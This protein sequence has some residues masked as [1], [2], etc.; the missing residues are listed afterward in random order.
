M[1]RR[2]GAKKTAA[3]VVENDN[4]FKT[5]FDIAIEEIGI[6]EVAAAIV[7]LGDPDP[8]SYFADYF[9]IP[10]KSREDFGRLL[11]QEGDLSYYCMEKLG[12]AGTIAYAKA[13]EKSDGVGYIT[14]LIIEL[15]AR[16]K[17]RAH[18]VERVIKTGNVKEA[19]RLLY[20]DDCCAA[21]LSRRQYKALMRMMS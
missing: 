16:G 19:D 8:A 4:C 1:A 21:S 20:H 2:L 18:V 7:R 12:T 10:K 13:V 5:I 14:P 3:A 15:R 17:V 11:A 6:Q 9:E